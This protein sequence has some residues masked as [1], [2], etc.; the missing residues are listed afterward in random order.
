[1]LQQITS[2]QQKTTINYY[3][4]DSTNSRHDFYC[5]VLQPVSAYPFMM[6]DEYPSERITGDQKD[7]LN[8][9]RYT[10]FAADTSISLIGDLFG[11][12]TF[13]LPG[14]EINIRMDKIPKING[15]RLINGKFLSP[16][17]YNFDYEGKNKFYSLFDSLTYYTGSLHIGGEINLNSANYV[18]PAFFDTVTGRYNQRL[19]YLKT[20]TTRYHLPATL[21]RLA[22]HEIK[23]AYI[24]NLLA[25]ITSSVK[26]FDY[27]D[28]PKV[29]LDSLN[30]VN[31]NDARYFFKAPV[32]NKTAFTYIYLYQD[33]K[34]F[35]G[36]N[37][38][39]NL[40][41]TYN[42]I[43]TR[44][45]DAAIKERLLAHFFTFVFSYNHN[46]ECKSCDSLLQQFANEFPSSKYQLY[47]DSSYNVYK[48][49][50][51]ATLKDMWATTVT[52]YRGN[53]YTLA[54]IL[55]NEPAVIDCWAS[56]CVPCLKEIPYSAEIKK[57]YMGKAEVIYLSFDKDKNR[58]LN[59]VKSLPLKENSYLVDENL[60]SA[61]ANYFIVAQIPRYIIFNA[62]GE[63]VSKNAPRPS[64]KEALSKILDSLISVN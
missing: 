41:R 23:A 58:W 8:H 42:T 24:K 43:N 13:I 33:R 18:L 62:K 29:Y 16:Y 27:K 48:K 35:K 15:K 60:N 38:E 2:G 4:P 21:Q 36:Y 1:M 9:T 14:D 12:E 56:W 53:K 31:F 20:Y 46:Q 3:Y 51:T 47:I 25:P 34:S 45:A 26:E 39:D 11:H 17:V 55:K 54:D 22:F 10:F 32:F 28:F 40:K 7:G 52:D 19:A 44:Y 37:T 50:P 64:K 57:K 6:E 49:K 63:V 30:A 5:P 61:F 59:K